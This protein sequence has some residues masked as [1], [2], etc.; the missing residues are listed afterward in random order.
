MSA[1]QT[2]MG[3]HQTSMSVQQTLM[4]VVSRCGE[5]VF[6]NL[7]FIRVLKGL[8]ALNQC[9]PHYPVEIS[10]RLV[11]YIE[12]LSFFDA[13]KN[14]KKYG[15][16]LLEKNS[17]KTTQLLKLLCTQWPVIDNENNN[18]NNNSHNLRKIDN[19]KA[20]PEEFIHLFVSKPDELKDFLEYLIQEKEKGVTIN[21]NSNMGNMMGDDNNII[22]LG[23]NNNNNN[24]NKSGVGSG[25]NVGL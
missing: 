8:T 2:S 6:S 19:P 9:V 22:A 14:I 5:H 18:S 11:E 7:L 10:K 15:Q 16:L 12:N 17:K 4:S 13:E 24:N 1:Q 3:I 20:N 25:S 21:D 23:D